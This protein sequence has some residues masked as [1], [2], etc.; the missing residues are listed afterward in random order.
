MAG[1]NKEKSRNTN[2]T[3]HDIKILINRL[4]NR[5]ITEA[6]YPVLTQILETFS[7]MAQVICE[8][9]ISLKRMFR[10]FSMQSEKK[11]KMNGR[12]RFG[13]KNKSRD[14]APGHGRNGVSSFTGG[15]HKRINHPHLKAGGC[16]PDCNRGK[17]FEQKDR[18]F[19]IRFFGNAP[20]TSTVF[21]CQVLRCNA[22]QKV[23]R[24]PL[25]KEAGENKY[26][27][28]THA[29]LALCTLSASVRKVRNFFLLCFILPFLT[30]FACSS[31]V[32][33]YQ[34]PF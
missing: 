16:C 12:K 9:N 14:K 33:I 6:D 19:E 21:D 4:N 25:P 29:M 7:E 32:A 5:E 23:F 1:K 10:I 22:C 15:E 3:S 13:E 11:H 27:D 2:I 17:L 31:M 24:T 28:S 26:S 18:G 34:V 20:I 30:M 8:K